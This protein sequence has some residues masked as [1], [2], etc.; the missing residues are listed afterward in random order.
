AGPELPFSDC[1][2]RG[3][4]ETE[5]HRLEHLHVGHVTV[6]VDDALDDDDAGDA[7]LA[8]H[9]RIRRLDAVDDHR[10]LDVP[11]DAQ[12][13]GW[14]RRRGIGDHSADDTADD[15]TDHTAFDAAL[16]AAFHARAGG[17]SG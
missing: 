14:R 8:G 4:V 17:R 7:R 16:D 9:F 12:R 1:F 5:R 15:A 2:D 6:F 3:V 13:R 11:A 10:R